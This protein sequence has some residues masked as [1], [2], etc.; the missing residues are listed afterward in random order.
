MRVLRA[1]AMCSTRWLIHHTDFALLCCRSSK[2]LLCPRALPRAC[3]LSNQKWMLKRFSRYIIDCFCGIGLY[4]LLLTFEFCISREYS[5]G[6]HREPG[7]CTIHHTCNPYGMVWFVERRADTL[8]TRKRSPLG[9]IF[10]S[11]GVYFSIHPTR[12]LADIE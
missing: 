12:L 1:H 3:S 7:F 9:V 6:S 5:S 10:S 4:F 11:F 8:W 2:P